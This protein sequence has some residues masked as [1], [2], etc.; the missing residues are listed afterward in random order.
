MT[1]LRACLLASTL[2][3]TWPSLQASALDIDVS[4]FKLANGMEVVV[5]PDHRAP[6]VTHM[7]WYRAGAADEPPGEAGVAHF[8]EHLLFKGTPK[9]PAGQFSLIVRKNGGEDNA[10]TTQDYTAY[11]QRIAKEHLGLVMELEAD[12]M[13]NLILTDKEVLP[14]RDVILEERRERVENDPQGL[15]GEQ[16][17]AAMYTAHPYGKPVIGWRNQMEALTKED[18]IS[19][20]RKHYTPANAILVVTGDVTEAEVKKL[21][22]QHYGTLKNSFEPVKRVRDAEPEPV[23]ARRV[24]MTDPR[25]ATPLFQRSY[26]APSYVTAADREAEALDILAEVLGGGS[27]SRLYRKLVVQDQIAAYTAAWY[28]GDARDYG[29]F[30]VYGSPVPGKSAADVEAAID[31]EIALIVKTGITPDELDKARKRLL[32]SAVYALDSQGELARIFGAALANGQTVEDIMSFDDQLNA[33]TLEDVKKA[34]AKVLDIRRSVT[35]IMLPAQ[36]AIGTAEPLPQ[37]QPST[38]VN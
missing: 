5:I 31:A 13:Q 6:V 10:F 18:A 14:E 20:Y 23:A 9:V 8:L 17:N 4:S 3:F 25:A 16:L 26:L 7:V 37:P 21:A 35:G 30:G 28:S 27:S 1:F 29:S 11:F 15:L 2:L 36:Q 12:R 34:A 38:T 24:T 19:F 22:E 33:V 32:A